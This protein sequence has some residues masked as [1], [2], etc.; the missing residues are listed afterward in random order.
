VKHNAAILEDLAFRTKGRVYKTSD[1]ALMKDPAIADLFDAEQLEI[2]RSPREIWDLLVIIAAALFVFDVAARRLSIDPR[3]VAMLA[4][5]A[6][7]RRAD[8]STDTVSAWKRT[9]EQASHQHLKKAVAIKQ[10]DQPVERSVRYQ[11]SD[12][13]RK[14]AIDVV[15]EIP[16]D[17]RAKPDAGPAARPKDKAKPDEEGDYTSRLLKAKRRAQQGG[18]GGPAGDEPNKDQPKP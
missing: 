4:G 18:Q 1:E 14:L 16:D 13:E 10:T 5:R 12:E 9:R 3:W 7:G 2:P 15:G 17:M 8:A 11:A 6:I